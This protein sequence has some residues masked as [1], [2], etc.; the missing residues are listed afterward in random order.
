M[1]ISYLGHSCFKIVINGKHLIFDP[2]ISPNE[3][4]S[5]IPVQSL[6]ADYVLLTHAHQDHMADAEEICKNTGAT[7]VSN[8]EI[9]SWFQKKGVEKAH[10]MNHGGSKR[11][12]FGTVKM[13]NA[14]HSSS[15]PDGSYGGN[16]AGF[17]VESDD[18]TFYYAGDTALTYDMKLIKE[19][20]KVDFAFMPIG[21]NFTMNIR[22][23]IK[24]ADFA[25]TS[26]IIPMHYDTF[27]YIKIDHDEVTQIAREKGI[28][29]L[30][31][32][33]GEKINL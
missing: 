13:V 30:L 3:L 29:L 14:I 4:A 2:F 7:L 5:E 24:A 18:K 12:E 31:M 15:F 19:E 8:F 26:K 17:V 23:A 20:F 21:D 33:I 10:P 25:G 1:E 9:V 6:E 22:D 27:P 28:E 16:P 11:F 32:K